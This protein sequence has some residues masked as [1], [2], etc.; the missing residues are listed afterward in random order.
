MN[1]NNKNPLV[2]KI[3]PFFFLVKVLLGGVLPFVE[4]LLGS[5]LS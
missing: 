1:V 2:L 3:S 4:I 5:S